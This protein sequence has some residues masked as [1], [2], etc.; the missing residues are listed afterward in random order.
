MISWHYPFI[1]IAI[2]TRYITF[3]SWLTVIVTG[4]LRSVL[5]EREPSNYQKHHFSKF[6]NLH[7]IVSDMYTWHNSYK[8]VNY[9]VR[10]KEFESVLKEMFEK[11][12]AIYARAIF[13]RTGQIHRE[14][15]GICRKCQRSYHQSHWPGQALARYAANFTFRKV[16]ASQHQR[17]TANPRLQVAPTN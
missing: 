9:R 13:H 2:G 15:S 16:C 5:Y 12:P 7:F 1:D 14:R 4:M 11:F 6:L 8:W 10:L 3:Y 17:Q